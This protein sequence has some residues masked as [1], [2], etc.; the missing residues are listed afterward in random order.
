MSESNLAQLRSR[1]G[2]DAVLVG[3]DAAA[4]HHTDWSGAP[5]PRRRWCCGRATR[6]A[7]PRRSASVMPPDSHCACRAAST[8]LA[9]GANPLAGEWVLSLEKLNAI[10]EIDAVGGT[11]I[12]QAG[13]PLQVLQEQV[14]GHG[15]FFRWIWAPAA[16]VRWAAMPPPTP[17]ASASCATA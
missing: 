8:G 7:W 17:A 2:E 4:R 10:E 1:L 6:P 12:V 9:G 3:A 13:V 11:A 16:V 14:A 5:H 15:W